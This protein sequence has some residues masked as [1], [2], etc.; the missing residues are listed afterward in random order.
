M[1]ALK[2]PTTIW[3]G[4]TAIQT[5]QTGIQGGSAPFQVHSKGGQNAI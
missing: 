3:M 5:R 2:C 1:T 4:S